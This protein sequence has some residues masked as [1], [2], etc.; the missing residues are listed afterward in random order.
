MDAQKRSTQLRLLS[1]LLLF[2]YEMLPGSIFVLPI[3]SPLFT[4]LCAFQ[5]RLSVYTA[6]V[7]LCRVM[8][9]W[10]QM[11]VKS[12]CSELLFIA[13]HMYKLN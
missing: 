2:K 5:K 6:A 9:K 10:K 7:T 13:C 3:D 1:V 4:S 12:D 11:Y 8:C